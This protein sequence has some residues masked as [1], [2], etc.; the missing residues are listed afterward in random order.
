MVDSVMT[1]KFVVQALIKRTLAQIDAKT[2]LKAGLKI[3]L[4]SLKEPALRACI[5]WRVAA[6][7]ERD[8]RRI[9]RGIEDDMI[10]KADQR[11]VAWVQ[12]ITGKTKVSLELPRLAADGPGVNIY[13]LEVLATPVLRQVREPEPLRLTLR[14]LISTSADSSEEAHRLLANLMFAAL[15][16]PD[17]EVE[18]EPVPHSVWQSFG[19]PVRP[20]FVVRVPLLQPRV[21]KAAPKVRKPLI[22]K[23]S[24]VQPLL[25]QLLGPGDAAIMDALVEVPALNLSTRTDTEGRFH[26]A[27]VPTQPPIQLLRVHAKGRQI[28]LVPPRR[29]SLDQPFVVHLNESQL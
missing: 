10:D 9:H 17:M 3:F 25:G 5:Y 6:G 18:A 1:G 4:K 24:P 28:D 16:S 2:V 7:P 22:V 12:S 29:P 8:Q 15:G 14:Y 11:M 26:F 21:V 19:Q 20:S 23:I 13:L 27:A